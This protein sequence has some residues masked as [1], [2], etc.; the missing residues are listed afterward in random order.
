MARRLATRQ[1]LRVVVIVIIVDAEYA[2]ARERAVVAVAAVVVVVA[3][4]SGGSGDI[5]AV[6]QHGVKSR[7]ASHERTNTEVFGSG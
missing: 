6:L 5:S 2:V 7:R 1:I 3:G 4:A